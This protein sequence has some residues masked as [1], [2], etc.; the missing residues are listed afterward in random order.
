MHTYDT[1]IS[2]PRFLLSLLLLDPV[3]KCVL[4]IRW[5]GP[6]FIN[7]ALSSMSPPPEKSSLSSVVLAWALLQL[8][9]LPFSGS[10]PTLTLWSLAVLSS[11]NFWATTFWSSSS[12]FSFLDPSSLVLHPCATLFSASS[13]SQE[14]RCFYQKDNLWTSSQETVGS[15][16]HSTFWFFGF[17]TTK[18]FH[19][20]YTNY[21][22]ASIFVG[23]TCVCVSSILFTLL[24]I[25]ETRERSR[26]RRPVEQ[27][28][29]GSANEGYV[30][31]AVWNCYC[32]K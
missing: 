26:G 24:V 3:F 25:P 29:Q 31:T 13:S 28:V 32:S 30:S 17:V 6:S 2:H 14:S 21:G 5:A 23:I 16:D 8:S 11:A 9:L 18:M 19:L 27:C 22:L 7:F 12:S 15:L 4:Q 20:L 1:I 10:P